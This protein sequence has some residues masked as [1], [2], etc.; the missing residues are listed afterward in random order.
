MK[1][2][3]PNQINNP[4]QIRISVQNLDSKLINTHTHT[5]DTNEI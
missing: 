4:S 1:S 5:H 3:L 2:S